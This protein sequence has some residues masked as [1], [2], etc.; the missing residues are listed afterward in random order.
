MVFGDTCRHIAILC[1]SVLMIISKGSFVKKLKES[2][3][4]GG[5]GF[6]LGPAGMT[7]PAAGWV[8]LGLDPGIQA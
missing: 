3:R 6:R 5:T 2:S 8:I 1:R 4:S 7:N